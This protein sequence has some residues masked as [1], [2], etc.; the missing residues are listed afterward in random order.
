MRYVLDCSVGVR[1]FVPQTYSEVAIR[2]LQRV[3]SGQLTLVAPDVVVSEFGHVLR[4]LV[5]GRKVEAERSRAFLVQFLA[6]PIDLVPAHA[7]ASRALDIAYAN[8]GT[9]YDALYIALAEREDL[10]VLT[11]DERMANAFA[12]LDRTVSLSSFA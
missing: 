3:Q 2:V 8:S 5:V 12:K 1:W 11:A 6:V 4:K 10:K 9:F 7:L